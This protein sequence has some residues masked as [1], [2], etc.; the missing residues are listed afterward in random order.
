MGSG[1]LDLASGLGLLAFGPSVLFSYYGGLAALVVAMIWAGVL[2][3]RSWQEAHE[4]IDPA[5]PEEL[6]DAFR[7][8][9]M[10]GELDE[11]EFNRVRKQL[12]EKR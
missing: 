1:N 9:W 6:L 2:A 5:T 8:A 11:Q 10:E 12:E 3:Y 4:E 7:Q